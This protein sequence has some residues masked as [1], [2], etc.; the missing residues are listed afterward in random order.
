MAESFLPGLFLA[1]STKHLKDIKKG[2]NVFFI[3]IDNNS[4]Q[5]RWVV[6]SIPVG[7]IGNVFR[8]YRKMDKYRL[9]MKMRIM[10]MVL[11]LQSVRKKVSLSLVIFY[12]S[13]FRNINTFS[14]SSLR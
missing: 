13:I 14:I 8:A 4:P 10:T 6:I 9:E 7:G 3:F 2:V 1:P 11:C 12:D 5:S